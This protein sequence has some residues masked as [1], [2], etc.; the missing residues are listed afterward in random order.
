M[1]IEEAI[2]TA[3]EYEEKVTDLYFENA[4]KFRDPV[5]RKIF[6][7]LAE[8]EKHHVEYLEKRLEEWEKD[9]SITVEKLDTIVPDKDIIKENVKKLKK[10]ASTQDF[11]DELSILKKALRLEVETSKFYRRMVRE[12]PA[13]HQPLFEKFVEIE[14]GHEAIVQAEIDSVQGL[15][16]W[17][18][19]M[20]FNLES[21]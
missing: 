15:G 21:G 8:E 18:D 4:K 5:P 6:L 16:F 17:F 13:E 2:K 3:L 1:T 19:F 7:A 11:A 14:E 10:Q 20:E 12:L 9:G